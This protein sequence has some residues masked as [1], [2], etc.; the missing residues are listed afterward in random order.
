MS[1]IEND[2]TPPCG[3]DEAKALREIE[4]AKAELIEAK[5]EIRDG[6]AHEEQG[7]RH[8]EEAVK[9]LERARHEIHIK[10][11]GEDYETHRRE[12]TPDEIIR[13]F[14]DVDPA[15]HY[16]RE[17]ETNGGWL[18]FQ[19]KGGILIPLHQCAEFYIASVGPAT[20]SDVARQG[21]VAAF[22][23]G[24]I[25]LGYDPKTLPKNENH[26]F[27]DYQVLAGSHAGKRVKI[28]LV[29]PQD[30]PMTP[31][32][33]PFVSPRIHPF[34]PQPGTHPT[35]GVHQWPNFDQTGDQWQYWSRPFRNWGASKK[36]VAAYIAHVFDLWA[37]Q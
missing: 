29:V 10:V 30:F 32:S 8:L 25:E 4:E 16:L 37:T 18:S 36:T 13:E 24:L 27:F 33:G 17:K 5:E 12:M 35:G 14:G 20:V 34:N 7:E 6:L 15:T 1:P 28:G 3:D 22:V 2:Q 23:S 21:G 11:D 9:D 26:V 31:P 19:G